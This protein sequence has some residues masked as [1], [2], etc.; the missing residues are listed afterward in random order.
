MSDPSPN[1]TP[2]L[3]MMWEPGRRW[4]SVAQAISTVEAVR[5]QAPDPTD[6]HKGIRMACDS[7][8]DGF[9]ALLRKEA[10]NE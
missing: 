2:D 8:I 10:G 7:I 5:A 6:L 9:E 3:D 4:M 1:T